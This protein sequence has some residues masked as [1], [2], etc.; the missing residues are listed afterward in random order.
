MKPVALFLVPL[1]ALTATTAHADSLQ[2]LSNA[3]D[4]GQVAE[5]AFKVVAGAVAAPFIIVGGVSAAP[6][7]SLAAASYDKN[8]SLTAVG[9][10]AAVPGALIAVPAVAVEIYAQ[11]PLTVSPETMTAHPAPKPAVQTDKPQ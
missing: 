2:N 8:D 3:Q 10:A 11:K 9:V 4:S 5:G 7:A 1:L 6:G